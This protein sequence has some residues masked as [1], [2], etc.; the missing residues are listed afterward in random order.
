MSCLRCA[1]K[2]GQ[3]LRDTPV[4]AVTNHLVSC[5]CGG[6]TQRTALSI[7]KAI[8]RCCGDVGVGSER[9]TPGLS[10]TSAHRP[11]D[12]VT[13]PMPVPPGY[14]FGGVHRYV[15]DTTV[16]YLSPSN[17]SHAADVNRPPTAEVDHAE[18]VKFNEVDKEVADGTRSALRPGYTFVGAAMCPRGRRGK[19][20]DRLIDNV[21]A[22]GA[23][24]TIGAPDEKG[25]EVQAKLLARFRA[26][27]SLG[28][29]RALM[30]A[31]RARHQMLRGI[32]E[33]STGLSAV[34]AM[35]LRLR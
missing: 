16:R 9:E 33:E 30:E 12:A 15:V 35:E 22:H 11:G 26:R 17:L 10:D 2:C 23:R 21:A 3:D 1:A 18:E 6:N 25:A 32:V 14:D 34:T 27:L 8:Q 13:Q 20:L 24:H 31:Y 7:T 4:L 28:A 19:N 29:H 5:A